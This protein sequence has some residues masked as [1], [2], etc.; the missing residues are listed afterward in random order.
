MKYIFIK[1]S[2]V[3]CIASTTSLLYSQNN[4]KLNNDELP[5]RIIDFFPDTALANVVGERLNKRYTDKVTTQELSNIHGRFDAGPDGISN[6]KGIG[7]LTGIDSFSC[8][9]NGVT[10]LPAEIGK[11]K[12][13]VW[14]DLAKA[15]ELKIIP[16]EIGNLKKLKYLNIGLTQL[17]TIPKEIGNLKSLDTLYLGSNNI[18]TIPKEIGNLKNLELLDISSNQIEKLPDEICNLMS[19]RKLFITHNKLKSLPDDIGNLTNLQTLNLNNN[20]LRYLPKSI[21]R[22]NN[23]TYLNVYDNDKLSEGYKKYLPEKLRNKK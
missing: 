5:E 18:K 7:Y 15:F 3:I 9:K 10:A 14:I 17:E 22:L 11:M 20:D 4:K 1:I 8:C 19:L 21:I 6:L 12:N 16:P 23:L 13:L 2:C